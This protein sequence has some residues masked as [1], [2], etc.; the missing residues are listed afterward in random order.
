MRIET[1]RYN[2]TERGSILAYFAIVVVL[3]TTLASVTAYVAQSMNA[4]VPLS[5]KREIVD[6]TSAST[7]VNADRTLRDCEECADAG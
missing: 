6:A 7:S 1:S 3:L 5:T 4:I 2:P